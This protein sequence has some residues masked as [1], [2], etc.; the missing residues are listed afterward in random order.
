M[1]KTDGPSNNSRSEYSPTYKAKLAVH[2]RDRF[3]CICC[4]ETIEDASDLDTDH[5][6]AR[7]KG[8]PDTIR[9]KATMC[10][11]CHEAKHGERDHAP[12]VRF[13]STGDMIEKDFRWFRHFWKKQFPSLTEFALDRRIKPVFNIADD[14]PYEAWHIPVG[15]L[16][17]LD[18]V[19]ADMDDV[20]YS[21]MKAHHYM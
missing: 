7:G 6:I 14:V 16:R 3:T 18:D 4:R 2:E 17:R 1:S 10:R 15:E 12:T 11:R 8:G 13:V 9:N 21:G 20:R 5:V 19:L